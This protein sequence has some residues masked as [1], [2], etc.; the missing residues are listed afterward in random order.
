MSGDAVS[1]CGVH[2]CKSSQQEATHRALWLGTLAGHLFADSLCMLS[3]RATRQ[4]QI[5][6]QSYAV[7]SESLRLHAEKQ[8]FCIAPA[9]GYQSD[10][11]ARLAHLEVLLLLP[12]HE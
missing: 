6:D 7:I 5:Q 8:S 3:L 4:L 1:K 12:A 10:R 2:C 11:A 9:G